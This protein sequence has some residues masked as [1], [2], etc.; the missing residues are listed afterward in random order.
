MT[1]RTAAVVA[2][3]V[4][5]GAL[6]AVIALTT[7][8]RPLGAGAAA[9]AADAS[10]DFT[11][12]EMTREVAFHDA[13]RPPGLGGFVVGLATAGVLGLTPLGAR[14]VAAAGRVGGSR[15][16]L[17]VLAGTIALSVVLTLVR[18][19]LSARAEVVRRRFGLSTQDWAGWAVDVAKGVGVSAALLAV[20]LL[21]LVFLARRSP[22]WWW[23]WAGVGAAALV[24]VVSFGYPVVVEPIFNRF[25]PMESGELR[26]S[27]L[28]LAERDGV[29]VDEVLVADAS[30]RTTALNAYVSGIGTTRRIV[31]YDTLLRVATPDEVRLV[32]AH[33]LGHV[34]EGDV[35]DGTLMGALGAA[36]AMPLLHLLI[37]WAPLLRRAGAE[38]AGD[39]RSIALVAF[40]VTA[41]TTL[42]GPVQSLVSRRVE[43]RADVHSLDLT[44]DAASFVASERRLAV[45]NLSDLEPN[46]ALYLMFASH[47][48]APE[49]IELARAWARREGL[50]VPPPLAA[51]A[52]A[53]G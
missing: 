28:E 23:A 12:A 37:G 24:V 44:A 41:L 20:S 15:W 33:E 46:R 19:P 26:E 36:A 40:L 38:G 11:P 6:A 31:V 21:A 5:G 22:D 1:P 2:L 17:T 14:L 53:R 29:A 16:P 13:V 18:L 3:L 35:R 45:T 8:W 42:T 7:P 49:R 10:R 50:P 51:D 25:T 32:V 27:L 30:R 43:A 4:L 48:S 34:V 47:P 9:S 52:G 39:P